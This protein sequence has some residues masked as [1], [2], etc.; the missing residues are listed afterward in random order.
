MMQLAASSVIAL[1]F[2]IMGGIITAKLIY[3]GGK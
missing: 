2:F 3:K 1:V